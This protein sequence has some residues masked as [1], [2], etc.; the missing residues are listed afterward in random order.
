MQYAEQLKLIIYIVIKICVVPAVCSLCSGDFSDLYTHL[1][2]CLLCSITIS[3][4]IKS[5]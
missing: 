1:E 2:V 5:M 3:M 4:V